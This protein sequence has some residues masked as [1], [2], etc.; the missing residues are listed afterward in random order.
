MPRLRKHLRALYPQMRLVET[1]EEHDIESEAY[2][3]CRKLF[4]AHPDLAGMYVTTEASIPV[5]DAAA[6]P[7]CSN[8]LP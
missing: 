6:T 4:K 1:I 3:K 7:R 2:D 8:S 5:L